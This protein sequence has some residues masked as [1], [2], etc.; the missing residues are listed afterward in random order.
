M[1][2]VIVINNVNVAFEVVNE[3]VFINSLEL[4]KVFEKDHRNI[5]RTINN[6]LDDDFTKLNFPLS[7]YTDST[8]RKL[9][10]YNLTRDGFSLLVMGFTGAKAYKWKI[11][12]IKAFNL[13]EAE[14]NRIKATQQNSQKPL[15]FLPTFNAQTK[16]VLK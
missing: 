4:S 7:E 14:L 6:L 8:G 12:F 5:L 3:R 13:M 1:N 15:L 2:E 16:S 11:E 10:C 9:P